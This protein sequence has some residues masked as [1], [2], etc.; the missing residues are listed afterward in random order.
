MHA[1]LLLATKLRIQA[2]NV[3]ALSGNERYADMTRLFVNNQEV[4]APPPSLS[5]LEEVIKHIEENLLPPD[6]VIRQ[7]SLDGQPVDANNCQADPS[8]ILGDLAGRERVEVFT[9]TVEQ[10]A[11]DSISEAESYMN[12]AE[13]LTPSLAAT[14]R[15]Y[16]GPETFERLKQLYDGFYWMSMLLSKLETVFKV[17]LDEMIVDGASLK[18][19]HQRFIS[20]LQQLVSAQEQEDFLLIADL[21]EFEI[22]P[23]IPAWKSLLAGI[24]RLASEPR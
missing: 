8:L 6:V 7:V 5:S 16:P 20:I 23:M 24:S 2:W 9:S 13:A 1:S 19:Q 18:E 10:I 3:P 11:L 22:V 15:D 21:L 12:R 14:F 17:K 4:L